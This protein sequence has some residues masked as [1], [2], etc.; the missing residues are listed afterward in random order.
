MQVEALEKLVK[1]KDDTISALQTQMALKPTTTIQYIPYVQPHYITSQ[2]GCQHEYPSLWGGTGLPSC[3]KCGKAISTGAG[4]VPGL[5]IQGYVG[6]GFGGN[7][8]IAGD[9]TLVE[10][11]A[12]E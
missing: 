2:W 6:G 4:V 1:I 7:Y 5:T 8:G 3:I 12:N 10:H 9:V 11:K